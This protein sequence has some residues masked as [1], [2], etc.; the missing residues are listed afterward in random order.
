[1]RLTANHL[2]EYVML[3]RSLLLTLFA[4]LFT[5]TTLLAQQKQKLE[6]EDYGQWQRITTTELSPNGSWFAYNISLVDGDGWLTFKKV[7]S[8]STGEH[9]FMHG[10]RP[11]FS[12]DGNWAAFLI[13]VSEDKEEQLKEQEKPVRYKLGLM[14][15]E[16]A[17]VDT[18]PNVS[19]FSFSGNGSY[20][21]MNKYKPEGVKTGGSDLVIHNLDTRTNQ[22]IGNVSEYGFNEE[23]T[24]LAVMIDASEKLGNGV[25]LYDLS[26]NTIRV[27]ESDTTSY[28]DLEWHD[29]EASLA[30]FKERTDDEY[31]DQ[32]RLLYAFKNVDDDTQKMVFDQREHDSFPDSMRIVE[33]RNPQWSEMAT[34]SFLASKNGKRRPMKKQK[35]NQIP[36][37]PILQKQPKKISMKIL[38][39]AM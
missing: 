7:G 9:K 14:N 31:E 30:F 38:T 26:E 20:L 24:F 1:M 28:S 2:T 4:F 29:E 12:D 25:H 22:V 35:P 17:E 6:L 21:A 3:K 15:L 19:G 34:A 36:Q 16:S 39:P 18:I 8:D 33:Y 11:A 5:T 32:T 13:G 27:L 10:V 37:P 23:G